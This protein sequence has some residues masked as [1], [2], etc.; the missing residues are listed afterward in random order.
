MKL[1]M[2]CCLALLLVVVLAFAACNRDTAQ[3]E[4]Q[5][6]AQQPATGET[7]PQP[8]TPTP[9][10]ATEEMVT[11]RALFAGPGTLPD[12]QMVV[13]AFNEALLERMPNTQID[14]EFVSS[15][16]YEER[17]RLILAANETLDIANLHSGD[18]GA[19][20]NLVTMSRMGATLPID[21]Y[22][23]PEWFNL[24]SDG[25]WNFARVDGATH[26]V[27]INRDATDRYVGIFMQEWLATEHMDVARMRQILTNDN[28][29]LPR[30]AWELMTDYLRNLQTADELRRGASPATMRWL[31]ERAFYS[32]FDRA[33]VIRHDGDGVTVEHFFETDDARMMFEFF[34]LWWREGLT[35]QGVLT[36][37]DRRQWERQ[38]DGHTLF[39]AGYHHFD[40]TY[41]GPTRQW[42]AAEGFTQGW[43]WDVYGIPWAQNFFV[44][45]V[46]LQGLFVPRTSQ[47]PQRA[48]DFL[49]HIFSDFDLQT[50]LSHGIEDVHWA[51]DPDNYNNIMPIVAEAEAARYRGQ[52][53]NTGN[54]LLPDPHSLLTDWVDYV[55]N[56]VVGRAI[57]TQLASFQLD[58]DP[59]AIQIE[60]YNAVRGE[61][62]W[63]LI[64][65]ATGNWESQLNEMLSQMRT[66]GADAIL[67]EIQRQV[68][69]FLGR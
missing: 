57:P 51:R 62:E 6:P 11:L 67:E 69:E 18:G 59:I 50:Y 38:E 40:P 48:V 24:I 10:P 30:E 17:L 53:W 21:N 8:P 54:M 4:Q 12:T 19:R 55:R 58:V 25:I 61:F 9:E 63:P 29:S 52:I 39:M 49:W 60:R 13:E 33:F 23:R 36:A 28:G 66:A 42:V 14:I 46:N 43:G 56:I 2:L 3:P 7:V 34:D 64:A 20:N 5:P 44:T 16:N 15:T 41:T 31:P 26:M 68:D 37:S 27:P 45:P 32:L 22:L 47:D 1:K 65:G 35:Y